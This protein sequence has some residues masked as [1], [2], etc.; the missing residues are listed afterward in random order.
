MNSGGIP[1]SIKLLLVPATCMVCSHS[2]FIG[3]EPTTRT[4]K[5]T[6]PN[7]KAKTTLVKG[8]EEAQPEEML[9]QGDMKSEDW[10]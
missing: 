7:C 2:F 5:V 9:S 3:V 6:C 4:M 8:E 1:N 10:W